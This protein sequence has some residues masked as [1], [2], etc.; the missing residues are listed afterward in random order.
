[1]YYNSTYN[2][3]TQNSVGLLL[4][5]RFVIIF[6]ILTVTILLI[7]SAKLVLGIKNQVY[8]KSSLKLSTRNIP[9]MMTANPSEMSMVQ[10]GL[11]CLKLAES[12]NFVHL[13]N[14][15]CSTGFVS[16]KE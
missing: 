12:C 7:S 4:S 13:E 15:I 16:L 14:G 6:F 10:C 8:K 1:M 11:H 5:V 9:W 3:K 2:G